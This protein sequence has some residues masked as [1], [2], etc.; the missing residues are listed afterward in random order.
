[1]E[2]NY[3][4]KEGKESDNRGE[5]KEDRVS[6]KSS[7]NVEKRSKMKWKSSKIV[8]RWNEVKWSEV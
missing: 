4:L 8:V 5:L 2:T 3:F 1:M 7:K 6:C